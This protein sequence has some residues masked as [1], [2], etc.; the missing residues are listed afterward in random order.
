M[1]LKTPVITCLLAIG[2]AATLRAQDI[3]LSIPGQATAP[4]APAPAAVPAA[5]AAPA[6]VYTDSQMLEEYGWFIG[7]RVGISDLNFT[8][9]QVETVLRG[10]TNASLG[11]ATP[12]ELEKIG[13]QMDTFIKA[14]QADY[15][16]KLKAKSLAES[17]AFL[18]VV[19]KKAGVT[20]LP[21]GL[22]YEIFAPGEGPVT[23]VTDT[24]TAHY[25][26]ALA[27]GTV[28]DSS[29]ARNEPVTFP[30]AQMIPGWVEGLQK[31]SKGGKIRLY[32]PPDLAYG[33]D[34][35]PGI[36]PG[37]TLVFDVEII[38]LAPTPPAP[39]PPA[40]ADKPA[41]DAKPAPAGK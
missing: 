33:D 28:F 16:A 34:M 13:P 22:C 20:V 1:K 26:G 38:D 39:M 36:P 18:T 25:I 31:V 11:K 27:N 21:S 19:K 30:L 5:P 29:V 40:E 8:T 4:A 3:K 7:K 2:L 37:S 14:K 12:F 35:R 17:A 10:I 23:K 6:V 24:V 41:A 9:E 32:V 15:M